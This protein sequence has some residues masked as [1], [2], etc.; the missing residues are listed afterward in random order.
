M[1]SCD[2]C[3]FEAKS[4]AGL[5]SHRRTKHAAPDVTGDVESAT[6]PNLLAARATLG[7]LDRLGRL[8]KIDEAR[9]IAVLSIAHALDVNPF[10]SQMWREYREAI[11]ELTADGDDDGGVA[12]LLAQLSADPRDASK[13]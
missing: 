13:A 1:A 11:K 10:N 9:R 12:E 5:A 7:E 8:E 3:E 2:D 6:G 4:P